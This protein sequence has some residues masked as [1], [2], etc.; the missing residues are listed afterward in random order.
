MSG[1]SVISTRNWVFEGSPSSGNANWP[2]AL[3]TCALVAL[4]KPWVYGNGLLC[5]TTVRVSG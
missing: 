4:T 3:I 5:R 2:W 1:R